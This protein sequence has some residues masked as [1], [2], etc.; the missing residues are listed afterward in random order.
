MGSKKV[1]IPGFEFWA[2]HEYFYSDLITRTMFLLKIGT[3]TKKFF[4]NFQ[5]T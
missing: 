5:L 1:L 2:C 3:K 4:G